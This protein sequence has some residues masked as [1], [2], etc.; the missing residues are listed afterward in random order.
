[1]KTVFFN[2]LACIANLFPLAQANESESASNAIGGFAP[3]TKVTLTVTKVESTKLQNFVST[4]C[5]VPAGVAK[6]KKGQKV[7]FTV[8]PKGQWMG[9]GIN[10][11][12]VKDNGPSNNYVRHHSANFNDDEADVFKDTLNHPVAADMFLYKETHGGLGTIPV[13]YS[14]KYNFTK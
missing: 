4:K 6:F 1:M 12:F 13:V 9:P 11:A 5:P 14:V 3:G 7:K 10:L 2:L 8:G